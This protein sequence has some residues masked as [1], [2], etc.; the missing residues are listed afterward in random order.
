MQK[1]RPNRIRLAVWLCAGMLLA[2]LWALGQYLTPVRRS[3]EPGGAAFGMVLID[4]AD[5]ETADS[6]HVRDC[7]VYVLA[8]G[9]KSPAAL[10]GVSPGDLLLHLNGLPVNSTGEFVARQQLF[11]PGER[12]ELH[13][14]RGISEGTYTVTLI[15]NED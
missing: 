5:E 7:G 10:A 12:V 13:F 2:C 6:Y 9:E 14:Q 11:E 3:P 4:I 1:Q 15:W 8:V